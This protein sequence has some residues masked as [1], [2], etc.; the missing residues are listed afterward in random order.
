VTVTVADDAP[1][2]ARVLAATLQ[3]A[4]AADPRA[5][6]TMARLRGSFAMRSA[7][8][9]Q[10][11]TIRF[12]KG[13][14]EVVGGVDPGAGVVVTADLDNLSTPGAPKPKVRG[15]A[16][17]PVLA[18]RTARLLEAAPAGGWQG[19]VRDWWERAGG[20]PGRP[21]GLRV[22]VDGEALVV[23]DAGRPVPIEVHGPAWAV[24][25]VFGGGESLAQFWLDG[26]LRLRTDT[27]TAWRLEG[28]VQALMFGR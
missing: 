20:R 11:A 7:K 1:P 13:E 5:A 15:A 4:A 14:V 24:Q 6:A 26:K 12:R 19:A 17:H 9:S 8:D 10:A 3:R 21:S 16:R 2:V 28:V 23:G 18:L 27:P 25:A 22:V